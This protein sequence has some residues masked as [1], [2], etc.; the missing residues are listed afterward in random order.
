AGA[1]RQQPF[2]ALAPLSLV[3]SQLPEAPEPPSDREADIR[4]AGIECPVESSADVV[5]LCVESIEPLALLRTDQ[6]RLGRLSQ[7]EVETG[8][9]APDGLAVP[10]RGQTLECVLADRL[11]HPQARLVPSCANGREQVVA[12][13]RLDRLQDV[14]IGLLPDV[15]RAAERESADKDA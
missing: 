4:L 5:Q 15:L 7:R 1:N 12:E 14:Q 11:E 8:V 13:E 10:A 9:P 2:H 3:V 6:A